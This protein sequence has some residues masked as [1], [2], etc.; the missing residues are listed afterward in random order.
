MK[1]VWLLLLLVALSAAAQAATPP[2]EFSFLGFDT[3]EK[4]IHYQVKILTAKPVSRVDFN[5]R[6]F[7]LHGK[8]IFDRPLSWPNRVEGRPQPLESGRTYEV[9]DSLTVEGA[10]RAQASLLRV[11]FRD[12]TGWTP[13]DLAW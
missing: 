12:G 11:V 6:V 1:G 7:D 3:A 5:L 13:A 8:M 10:A 9:T 4:T 2:V